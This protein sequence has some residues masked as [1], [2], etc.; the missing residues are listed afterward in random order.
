MYNIL[1][2]EFLKLKKSPVFL[3]LIIGAIAEPLLMFFGELFR[4]DIVE[5]ERYMGNIQAMTFLIVGLLLFTLIAS[6]IY[7]REFT[8]KVVYTAYSYPASKTKIFICKLI[9]VFACIAFVYV[10]QFITTLIT[11]SIIDHEPLAMDFLILNVKIYCYS[12]LF[13]FTI[14]PLAIFIASISRNLVVPMGYSVIGSIITIFI[15]GLKEYNL[16]FPLYYPIM[17]TMS[18]IENKMKIVIHSHS[19]IIAAMFFIIT[20]LL[21]ILYY[22]KHDIC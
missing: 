17:P 10:L 11:G 19:I 3:L 9:T 20:S 12:L 13:Q 2:S 22:E 18:V 6:Y 14:V 4:G 21:C 1:Y 7:V 15:S 16:Y 5:W 8:E